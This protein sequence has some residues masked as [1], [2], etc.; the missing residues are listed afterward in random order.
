MQVEAVCKDSKS[1]TAQREKLRRISSKILL[2]YRVGNHLVTFGIKSMAYLR[3]TMV[4][5]RWQVRHVITAQYHH[6]IHAVW[7][8]EVFYVFNFNETPGNVMTLG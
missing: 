2:I 6:H 4:D 8:I 7:S 3:I 1:N 5:S